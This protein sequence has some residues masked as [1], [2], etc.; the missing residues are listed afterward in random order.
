MAMQYLLSV[1]GRVK[2]FLCS[3]LDTT[4][5]RPPKQLAALVYNT[6]DL[7]HFSNSVGSS[8]YFIDGIRRADFCLVFSTKLGISLSTTT[9]FVL[10]VH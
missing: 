7:L 4:P 2:H 6:K 5:K 3:Q 9:R 1:S 8:S 10:Q